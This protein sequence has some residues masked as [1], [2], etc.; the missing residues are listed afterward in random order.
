VKSVPHLSTMQDVPEFWQI[1]Q[2]GNSMEQAALKDLPAEQIRAQKQRYSE[3]SK[4][5]RA[6]EGQAQENGV[7]PVQMAITLEA[8]R[9]SEGSFVASFLKVLGSR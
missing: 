4:A 1:W 8:A 7:T 3:W 9:I 6:L 2:E 5:A